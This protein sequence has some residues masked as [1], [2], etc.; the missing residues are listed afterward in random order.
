MIRPRARQVHGRRALLAAVCWL[1]AAC[2]PQPAI[3]PATPEN[4]PEAPAITATPVPLRTVFPPGQVFDYLAQPGDTLPAVAAHFN[5]TVE[6]ILAENPD[7]PSPITTLPAGYLVRVPSYSLPLTTSA[8]HILP[9][10][11]AING[12]GAVGFDTRVEVEGQPGFLSSLTDFAQ[13]KQRPAWDVINVVARSYSIHPRLLLA[14]LEHRTHALTDPFPD[15]IYRMYPL[16]YVNLRYRG[17]YRQLIW[18]AERFNDSFYAWR[19]GQPVDLE[20]ADGKLARPDP[21]QNAGTVG[22]QGILAALYGEEGFAE[23]IG[24]DGLAATWRTLWG[25]PFSREV[26]TIPASLQ[27][28]QWALPFAPNRVW[29]FSGG[30]HPSW[31]DS[32][33]WGALDFAP[34][35]VAGGCG[36]SSEW[37]TA[38]ADGVVT[39]SENA[40]VVLDLDG[41]GDERTGWVL[42]FYHVA[43]EGRIPQGKQ[44]TQGQ[45]LGHPSCEGGRATGTHF[46]MAR[47]FNGE[48]MP[49][50]GPIPFELDGWIAA[51]GNAP[52]EG[53]LTRG[54]Q[55]VSACTCSTAANRILYELPKE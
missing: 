13:R 43:T 12:P 32:L 9:D 42:F 24:P 22:V 51:Y 50:G 15:D 46:H 36:F 31:G 38:P 41:D 48:W 17:L 21:W 7:L 47:R 26:V 18:A 54:S 1:A 23:A 29:D 6:Q 8:F 49:A 11:E 3:A 2:G 20:L 16:G 34:P 10:S 4:T 35:A 27:Q 5:T 14:L 40:T 37:F 39:R 53:T 30:P 44:V 33:P 28:P 19:I 55:T 25:D 45:N 52:Y